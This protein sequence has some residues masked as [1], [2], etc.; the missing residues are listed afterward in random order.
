[1]LELVHEV[2]D[3]TANLDHK[4]SPISHSAPAPK[5]FSNPITTRLKGKEILV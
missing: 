4:N 3:N 5:P 2:L 1:M